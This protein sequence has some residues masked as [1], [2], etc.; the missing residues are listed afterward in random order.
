[1]ERST[2]ALSDKS[3]KA[4]APCKFAVS[5]GS[6]CLLLEKYIDIDYE[7]ISIQLYDG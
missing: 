7:N 5:I 4:S 1:M 3:Y 2:A 6:S